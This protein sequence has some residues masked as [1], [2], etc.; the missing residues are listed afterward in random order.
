MPWSSRINYFENIGT[1]KQNLSSH[2]GLVILENSWL[3][4][5]YLSNNRLFLEIT[6][7]R[8]Q[9]TKWQSTISVVAIDDQG[10]M[11]ISY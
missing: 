10:L 2:L 8:W 7:C 11:W 9:G 6:D 3:F 4:A 1:N 5:C